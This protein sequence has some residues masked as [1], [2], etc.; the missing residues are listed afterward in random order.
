MSKNKIWG[1]L[2]IICNENPKIREP[3]R[4]HERGKRFVGW[5]ESHSDHS[6]GKKVT[7][8]LNFL[9]NLQKPL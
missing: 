2:T 9:S 7:N 3:S 6:L 4:N 1:Q 5:F 8:H